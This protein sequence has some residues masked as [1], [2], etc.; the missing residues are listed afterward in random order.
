M[1]TK[2]CMG[3]M[4]MFLYDSMRLHVFVSNGLN[5]IFSV[6]AVLWGCQVSLICSLVYGPYSRSVRYAK[7]RILH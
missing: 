5:S 7:E 4:L 1:P 2:E 3:A 6:H